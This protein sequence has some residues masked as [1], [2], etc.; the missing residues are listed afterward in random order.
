MNYLILP[1]ERL[2]PLEPSIEN[3]SDLA[4]GNEEKYQELEVKQKMKH[5]SQRGACEMNEFKRRRNVSEE[6]QNNERRKRSKNSG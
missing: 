5:L 2:L 3:V 1:F 6:H 4:T